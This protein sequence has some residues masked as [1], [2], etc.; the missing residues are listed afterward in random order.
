MCGI[1]LENGKCYLRLS[2]TY[3]QDRRQKASSLLQHLVAF[4][5]PIL[6]LTYIPTWT[7]TL[8]IVTTS[9]VRLSELPRTP[10]PTCPVGH[11]SEQPTVAT[12]DTKPS[13]KRINHRPR[14]SPQLPSSSYRYTWYRANAGRQRGRKHALEIQCHLAYSPTGSPAPLQRVSCTCSSS[15][16]ES[17][18]DRAVKV[19]TRRL[20]ASRT[21]SLIQ[22][23]GR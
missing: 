13:T 19:Q 3:E 22:K 18:L 2:S 7:T 4:L 5:Q 8:Y 1:I 20:K 14:A 11:H 23:N 10:P 9:F 16:S 17:S 6:N 15:A 12:L 21:V